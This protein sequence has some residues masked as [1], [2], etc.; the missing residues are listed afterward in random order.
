MRKRIRTCITDAYLEV[1][2]C[3]GR[4]GK[5]GLLPSGQR[6]VAVPNTKPRA[7]VVSP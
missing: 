6:L 2:W 1:D 5:V 3:G 7:E 4:D